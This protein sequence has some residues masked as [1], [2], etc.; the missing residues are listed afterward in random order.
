MAFVKITSGG[1]V[2][3]KKAKLMTDASEQAIGLMFY[4]CGEILMDTGRESISFTAIHTWLCKSMDVVWLDSKKRV[5]EF[6]HAKPWKM[7]SPRKP[8]R[9]V[10][11]TTEKNLNI[12]IGDKFS[13]KNI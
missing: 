5:V 8:A 4:K 1:K 11:E 9:Y 2:I 12:K 7:Y 10:F 13:I 3:S 6:V